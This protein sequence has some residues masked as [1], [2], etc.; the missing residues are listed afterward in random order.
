MGPQINPTI[1]AYLAKDKPQPRG[2]ALERLDPCRNQPR[3]DQIII[4]QEIQPPV[5]DLVQDKISLGI[6]DCASRWSAVPP[7]F[8]RL[9]VPGSRRYGNPVIKDTPP[10]MIDG[11]MRADTGMQSLQVFRA[12][13]RRDNVQ[14]IVRQ[15]RTGLIDLH[16]FLP[17]WAYLVLAAQQPLPKP[18]R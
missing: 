15:Q 14:H 12:T 1:R 18:L 9:P 13:D 16:G 8:D 10:A 2:V 3:V 17:L 6:A 5:V 4:V 11:D 7:I